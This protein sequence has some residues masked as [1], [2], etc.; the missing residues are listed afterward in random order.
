MFKRLN[1]EEE[2]N[3]EE[4]FKKLEGL[5]KRFKRLNNKEVKKKNY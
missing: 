3:D 1:N 4:E 5:D 2:F